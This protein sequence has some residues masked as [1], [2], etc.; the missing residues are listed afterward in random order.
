VC[1]CVCVSGEGKQNF[2]GCA[3]LRVLP[4]LRELH[5][6]RIFKLRVET[7]SLPAKQPAVYVGAVYP[8]LCQHGAHGFGVG[9]IAARIG[10]DCP[11]C[12]VFHDELLAGGPP[13]SAVRDCYPMSHMFHSQPE[14]TTF[15]MGSVK[16]VM[17]ILFVQPVGSS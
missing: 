17:R 7:C 4:A 14:Q 6:V 2:E 15:V 10:H 8:A 9:R 16:M 1:V 5:A 11:R 3:L 12:G 13:L